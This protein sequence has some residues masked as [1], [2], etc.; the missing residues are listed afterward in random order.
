MST[1]SP[2]YWAVFI[3][4]KTIIY[5]EGLAGLLCFA[6]PCPTTATAVIWGLKIVTHER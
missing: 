6:Y 4:C 3:Y 5:R 2:E 1:N